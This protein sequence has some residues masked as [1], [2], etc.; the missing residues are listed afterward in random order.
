MKVKV[1]NPIPTEGTTADDVSE[2]AE[3][4]RQ[5]MLKVFHEHD[6]SDSQKDASSTNDKKI[7]WC[8]NASKPVNQLIDIQLLQLVPSKHGHAT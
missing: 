2:L 4:V 7:N 1:L 5:E 3:N 8:C 6:H